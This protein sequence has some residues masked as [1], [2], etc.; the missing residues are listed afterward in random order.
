L[1]YADALKAELADFQATFTDKGTTVFGG[2]HEH[3]DLVIAVALAVWSSNASLTEPTST[4]NI[5][6]RLS[7]VGVNFAN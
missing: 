5:R 2:K 1:P 6:S 3:E 4:A 7:R